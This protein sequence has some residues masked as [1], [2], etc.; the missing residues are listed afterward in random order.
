M[1]HLSLICSLVFLLLAG[2][3]AAEWVYVST[4]PADPDRGDNRNI[5]VFYNT[6]GI[7]HFEDFTRVWIRTEDDSKFKSITKAQIDLHRKSSK[8]RFY[9]VAMLGGDGKVGYELDKPGTEWHKLFPDDCM[10]PV[11]EMFSQ[12]GER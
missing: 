10:F 7:E 9:Y 12:H 5:T 2:P 11:W 4:M 3:V 8:L 1:R 6:N